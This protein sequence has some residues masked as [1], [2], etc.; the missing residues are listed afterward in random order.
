MQPSSCFQVKGQ[1]CVLFCIWLSSS[2]FSRSSVTELRLVFEQLS[3]SRLA[4]LS[5]PS[6]PRLIRQTAVKSS[7]LMS[8]YSRHRCMKSPEIG[9]RFEVFLFF[10]PASVVSRFSNESERLSSK[11]QKQV[12]IKK[13]LTQERKKKKNARQLSACS[14][15][16]SQ[17][18]CV[19]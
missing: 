17:R 5:L 6:F 11:P 13:E 8:F 16:P 3:E 14:Q 4:F 18:W 15:V 19:C 12:K 10:C 1:T 2:S 7:D 9:K